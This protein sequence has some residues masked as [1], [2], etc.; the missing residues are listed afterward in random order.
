[1]KTTCS[2]EGCDNQ[3]RTRGWCEMHYRRWY[4]TGDPRIVRPPGIAASTARC[5]VADCGARAERSGLCSPHYQRHLRGNDPHLPFVRSGPESP[6]WAAR[7]HLTYDTLHE[8]LR[9]TRGSAKLMPC[10]SCGAP[11]HHWAY[12]HTDPNPL[13]STEGRSIGCEY[14][15]DLMAYAPMCRVCHVRFDRDWQ[16]LKQEEAEAS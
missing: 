16:V 13:V 3:S 11:A 7:E 14:S 8:Q 1:M 9:R 5:E 6:R 4:R 2:I 10:V 15:G 12:Q